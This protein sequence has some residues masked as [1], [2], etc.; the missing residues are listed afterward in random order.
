M[1]PSAFDELG[2]ADTGPDVDVLGFLA[3]NIADQ[4][5]SAD[6][7]AALEA[8]GK[9]YQAIVDDSPDAICVHQAGLFVYVNPA[10]VRFLGVADAD[11]LLNLPITD[12]VDV[13]SHQGV[14]DRLDALTARGMSSPP[15]RATLR[16]ADGPLEVESISVRTTWNGRP[17]FQVI[18]RDVT[19]ED[20]AAAALR[21]Q[22]AI[23]SHVSNAVIATGPD[24]LV[25]SWNPAAETVYGHLA[26]D[27]VG[28]AVSELVGAPLDP[29]E[30]LRAGGVVKANHRRSD[31]TAL[32]VRVSAAP[33]DGGHVLVCADETAQRR[34]EQHFSTVVASLDEGVIV[35]DSEGVIETANQAAHEILGRSP[36]ELL[37]MDWIEIAPRDEAG[38]LVPPHPVL[39]APDETG[40]VLQIRR[41]DSAIVWIRL[42]SRPLSAGDGYTPT[43]MVTSFTDITEDRAIERRLEHEATHDPL[44][45]LANRTVVLK[46]LG[47]ALMRPETTTLLFIDLDNFKVINDSLGHLEG[48]KML[49]IVGRRL[50]DTLPAGDLVGRLGGDEFVVVTSDPADRHEAAELAERLRGSLTEPI[51]MNGRPLRVDASVGIAMATGIDARTAADFL[52]DADVA[53]YQAKTRGRGRSE[54]FD[55][56]LRERIQ[57]RLRLE[58]DLRTAVRD[59]RLWTAYQPIT[60]LKTGQVLAIEA[61]LRW[62]HPVHGEIPPVEFLTLAE[63]SELIH[64][65]GKQ[66]LETTTRE[67]VRQRK[68]T[69]LDLGLAVNL[70]S[71]QVED[72]LLLPMVTDALATTGLPASALCLEMTETAL[73]RDHAA[74]AAVLTEL[75]KLGV[76]LAIDDFGTGYSSLAQ[77]QRLTV[78]TLKID[79]SFI[80]GLVGSKDARAIVTSIVAMAH[81]VNLTV[82]AEGVENE[83]QVI[84]LRELG[85][86]Q[87]Q[88]FHLGV[89]AI[90]SGLFPEPHESQRSERASSAAAPGAT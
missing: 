60:D 43:A 29:G 17:A 52:R 85:C 6:H 34:A 77:L 21:S 37:G 51:M 67:L 46:G 55:V 24:G 40:L 53:M 5:Q 81:A 54:F 65:I 28:R 71:R 50:R 90:P 72:P 4:R 18:M 32:A 78:D 64:V 2:R 16:G 74:A 58:Q 22:A 13:R 84:I 86:D 1:G 15:A 70:S 25:T 19:A 69:G 3:S 66:V 59:G 27:A 9:Q 48:D 12:I 20:V 76:R 7:H 82:I 41:P 63:E 89:P 10:L 35:L 33:M 11:E 62:T 23:I 45:G 36:R 88:G 47:D 68:R 61:L 39:A 73:M 75:R 31:G 56:E 57:R 79:R 44:T 14:H 42:T 8:L 83:D 80:A 38:D 49:R 30:V 26:A 87:A